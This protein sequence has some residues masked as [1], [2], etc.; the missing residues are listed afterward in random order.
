MLSDFHSLIHRHNPVRKAYRKK[1]L[2]THPDR[3]PQGATD[4]Q[5][6]ISQEQ[7]RKVNEDFD[8][9]PAVN[10]DQIG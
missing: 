9:S 7:F 1:A 3:L 6:A 5:R 8:C 4:D 10:L 2:L